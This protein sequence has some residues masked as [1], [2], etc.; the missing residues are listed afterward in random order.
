MRRLRSDEM[1]VVLLQDFRKARVFGKKSVARMHCVGTG[2]LACRQQR[3]YVEITVA[4][5]RR[6]DAH[7]FVGE[8]HMH[9]ILICSRMHGDRRNSEF[10]A[11]AQHTERYLAP[12]CD[13]DFVEHCNICPRRRASSTRS[14]SMIINGSPNSTGWP[15][16]TRIW[17]TVPARGVGIWFM[18]FI[19][20]MIKSVSPT[21]TLLPTSTN[22][23]APGSGAR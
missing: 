13:K 8:S 4:Y 17:I 11:G 3:R 21:R 19:A 16:S 6:P 5:G 1:D 18:V 9:G 12:V 22:G 2:D 7:A 14:Y 15:S 23:L 20:S 10:L